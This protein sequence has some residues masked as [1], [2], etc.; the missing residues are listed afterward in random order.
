MPD[1]TLR[2]AAG[3][4]AGGGVSRNRIRETEVFAPN[5][6][7][8]WVSTVRLPLVSGWP[9]PVE[10]ETMVFATNETGVDWG[11]LHT[12]RYET[13]TEAVAGHAD[14][15]E[16]ARCGEFSTPTPEGRSREP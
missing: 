5:G 8:L 1:E 14:V 16:R 13:E 4:D 11:G 2:A 6:A 3:D 12:E 10:Y 9:I 15:V 7:K